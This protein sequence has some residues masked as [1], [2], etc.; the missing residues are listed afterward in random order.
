MQYKTRGIV[1]HSI[2]Y[3]DN[4]SIVSVY[5]EEFGRAS[6]MVPR[7]KSKKAAAS[8]ALFMPLAVLDM[9]VEHMPK[10]DVHKVKEC[11]F[12]FPQSDVF[13][14]PVKNILALFL[15]E[16]LY[17]TLKNPEPDT[18]LFNYIYNSI[19]TLETS[20]DGIANFHIVFLFNLLHY[21][22]IYP[23]TELQKED[24][25]FDLLNGEFTLLPPQ[26]RHFLSQQESRVFSRLLRMSFENMS[27]YGFSRHES[28]YIINR[29]FDYYRLH[30]P[31]FNEIKSLSVMQSLFE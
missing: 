29:I 9:D 3:K 20:E 13:C 31:D 15:A 1:L 18:S 21:L 14:H 24:S 26:H 25:Y 7:G 5:T 17:R 23:N 10:R 4:Y 11:R 27:L 6:Y 30:I 28:V 2:P 16:V 22:G 19:V 8:K 12:C